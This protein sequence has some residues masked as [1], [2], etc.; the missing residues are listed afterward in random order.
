MLSRFHEL[1]LVGKPFHDILLRLPHIR[2]VELILRG[3]A[4]AEVLTATLY[5]FQK[6]ERPPDKKYDHHHYGDPARNDFLVLVGLA[7]QIVDRFLYHHRGQN[8]ERSS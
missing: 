3:T 7:F 4:D 2:E 8:V 6:K 5:L 1:V